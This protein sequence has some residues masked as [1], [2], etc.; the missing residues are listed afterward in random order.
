[1]TGKNTCAISVS[2][3]VHMKIE[4]KKIELR[5]KYNRK[6]DMGDIADAIIR[7]NINNVEVYL[8]LEKPS[9]THLRIVDES[10]MAGRKH[11]GG[12]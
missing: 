2:D 9:P 5:R 4:E 1:M 10:E 6:F 12:C 3:E 7:N 8:G 11:N